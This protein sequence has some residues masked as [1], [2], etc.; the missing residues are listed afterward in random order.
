MILEL[1]FGRRS[2]LVHLSSPTHI[3]GLGTVFNEVTQDY[4]E[5]LVSTYLALLTMLLSS[6]YRMAPTIV[7]VTFFVRP[8]SCTSG[9]DFANNLFTDLGPILQLFGERVTIQFLSMSMRWADHIIFAM[10]PLGIITAIVCA[11]R[12]SGPTWL[13]AAI[14]RA[15]ETRALVEAEVM[16]STS[17]EV[18]EVWNGQALV[19]TAGMP[20]ILEVIYFP[21]ETDFCGLYTLAQAQN[22]KKLIDINMISTRKTSGNN[23]SKITPRVL[24]GNSY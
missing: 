24:V 1:G 3:L 6:G 2:I 20:Q 5:P 10:V 14:G 8:A 23:K 16:S 12:A 7:A 18:S 21:D 11:I 9:D 19:R 17:H 22:A 4:T 15:R 13:R